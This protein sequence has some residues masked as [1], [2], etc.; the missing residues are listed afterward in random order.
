MTGAHVSRR[1]PVCVDAR[2]D[3]D[4][5]RWLWLAKIVLVIPHI[6][7]LVFLWLA[8][9]ATTFV[10]GFAILFTGRYP[11]PLFD[12]AVGVL[13]W[14]WRVSFYAA[15]AFAT[16]QYPPF[17]LAP[18]PSYPADLTVA[19]PKSLSR[20]LVLVKWWLLAIP[21]YIVVAF[22]SGGWGSASIGLITVLAF[23][24]IVTVAATGR[25]P[26]PLFDLIIG[27]N[28]WCLRVAAYAGLMTDEYPP[29]RLDQG[30]IDPGS[31]SPAV[32]Q[33]VTPSPQPV[34]APTG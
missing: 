31:Q 34:P 8:A 21:Q 27:L 11:R 18:D 19:Y 29:F 32:P 20:G 16:D 17:S 12:F 1:Y 24:A 15:G 28:R 9:F 33:S 2:L 13:R 30:G 4:P 10:S 23:V 14:S 26:L 6:V 25:Y 5:H 7:V 22:F 3:R